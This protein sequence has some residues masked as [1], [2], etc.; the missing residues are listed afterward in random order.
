MAISERAIHVKKVEMEQGR[1]MKK[2]CNY[3]INFK[4]RRKHMGIKEAIS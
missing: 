1:K 3:I 4:N 2:Y